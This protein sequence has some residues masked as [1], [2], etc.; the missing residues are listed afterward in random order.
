MRIGFYIIYAASILPSGLCEIDII[1]MAV[2]VIDVIDIAEA[3]GKDERLRIHHIE[4]HIFKRLSGLRISRDQSDLNIAF[5]P[6]REQLP[7]ETKPTAFA[8]TIFIK[9][10]FIGIPTHD[11]S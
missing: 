8:T 10:Q 11:A 9:R 4:Q 2:R 3:S 7:D 5:A 6:V 1:P